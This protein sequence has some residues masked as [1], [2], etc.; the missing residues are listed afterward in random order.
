MMRINFDDDDY[1]NYYDDCRPNECSGYNENDDYWLFIM[2]MMMT[3]DYDDCNGC[4]G[5]ND[6][7]IYNDYDDYS[8]Y[9]G[10]NDWDDCND[11]N[12]YDETGDYVDYT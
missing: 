5:C 8:N 12:D 4:D 11:Y 3:I 6:C 9:D 2:I 10:Y 1:Y 7:D